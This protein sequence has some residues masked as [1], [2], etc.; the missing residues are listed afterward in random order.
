[1]AR[2][3]H[4]HGMLCVNRPLGCN[5]TRRCRDLTHALCR[6]TGKTW[7]A[8]IWTTVCKLHATQKCSECSAAVLPVPFIQS[9]HKSWGR[10]YTKRYCLLKG[11]GKTRSFLCRDSVVLPPNV[12]MFDTP[13]QKLRGFILKFTV[14]EMMQLY[15]KQCSLYP[16]RV[17]A[18]HFMPINKTEV[19]YK[20]N[21]QVISY[22]LT[23]FIWSMI[24]Q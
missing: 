16:T 18:W 13:G 2:E 7:T 11:R 20:E 6:L 24:M 8:Y 5:V 4:R 19:K 22:L 12:K 15:T 9:T 23:N 17:L 14:Y 3:R 21:P 10:H 1:M